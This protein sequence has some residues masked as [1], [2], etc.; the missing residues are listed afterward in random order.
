M[1][2]S[3]RL[4]S[5][6]LP[7]TPE[8]LDYHA[9]ELPQRDD[10]CGA[11]CGALALNAAGLSDSGGQ[12][13]DQDTVALAAGSIV[14][15]GRD[16]ASL[17]GG[18]G[19]RRDYRLAIPTIE[20][21]DVSGTTAEGVARAVEALGAGAVRAIP[22]SGPWDAAALDGLFDAAASLEH[23]VTLIANLATHHLWGATGGGPSPG[24]LLAYLLDGE[25]D[26]PAPDWEVG[27]FACVVACTDGP[28]GRL[29]TVADTYPAL[30][31][32]GLH[33]QPRERLASAIA[34]TDKPAG[35]VLA[36]VSAQEASTLRERA[37]ALGLAEGLWD[38]GTVAAAEPAR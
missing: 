26:G 19:G 35:G 1:P 14:S 33:L 27:H 8:L 25:L 3:R 9:R 32:R 37:G 12:P 5:I 29:Y 28:A 11:F 36:V 24:Q 22:L 6:L 10:L 20:D 16:P 15:S 2:G 23:P 34:R 7:G 31:R 4:E 18:E 21:P 13:T 17:P 30:G 38:N